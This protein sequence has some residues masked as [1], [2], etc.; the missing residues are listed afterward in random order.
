MLH[1]RVVSKLFNEF[2]SSFS[3]IEKRKPFCEIQLQWPC[4]FK[5]K[6]SHAFVISLKIDHGSN[7]LW[8][9]SYQTYKGMV[10]KFL[11]RLRKIKGILVEAMIKGSRRALTVH[12]IKKRQTVLIISVSSHD[13]F[14]EHTMSSRATRYQNN[15]QYCLRQSCID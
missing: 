6:I 11:S 1:F 3:F 7:N 4:V 15:I 14:S 2:L 5:C 9:V 12:S 13:T 10:L 8:H